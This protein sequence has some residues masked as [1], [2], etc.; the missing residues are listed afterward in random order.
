MYAPWCA[1]CKRLDPIWAHVAQHLYSTSVRVGRVDCT[2]FTSVAHNFNIRGYPSILLWENDQFW[3]IIIFEKFIVK[4]WVFFF[5]NKHCSLKGEQQFT[6]NGDRTKEEIV[7]FALR[8]NGP[9]VQEIKKTESFDTIK[10]DRGLY[11]LYVGER[12][13]PLW[14]N[15]K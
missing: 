3:R 8:L 1:H 12:S 2:R 7:K 13:S 9:P 11:F 10:R 6:Y 15:K 4:L 5:F 14:V